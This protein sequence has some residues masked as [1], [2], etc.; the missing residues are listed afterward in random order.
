MVVVPRGNESWVGQRDSHPCCRVHNAGCCS[1]TMANIG[2]GR[3]T[4]EECRK[5]QRGLDS[6]FFLQP[7]ALNLVSPAGLAPAR[8]GLKHRSLGSLHSG[9]G[10]VGSWNAEVGSGGSRSFRHRPSHFPLQHWCSHVDSH[11]EPPPSQGGVQDLLHLG[12]GKL[13]AGPGLAPG[14]AA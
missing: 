13:A 14:H 4:N 8:P 1:Y 7:S 2:E 9:T 6:S 10:E 11:H 5:G 12:S 3:R